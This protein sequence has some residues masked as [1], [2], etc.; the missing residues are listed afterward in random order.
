MIPLLIEFPVINPLAFHFGP[1]NVHWYGIMYLLGFL[2]TYLALLRSNV[3]ASKSAVADYIFMAALGVILGGRLG[4]ILFYNLSYYILHPLDIV[5]LW[6]GG[7]SFH[8]GLAGVVI[9]TTFFARIHKMSFWRITDYIVLVLPFT[10]ALGRI[11]NFINGE[12][13]GRISSL[14]WA[15]HFP[16]ASGYRHPSQLYEALLHISFGIILLTQK[17]LL[18]SPALLSSLFLIGYGVIRIFVEFFREPD[19]QIGFIFHY[20]TLG[21][22]LS[23]PILIVGLIILSSPPSGRK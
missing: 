21:Q 18:K 22:I 12:L 7:M 11:G 16:L 20:F 1:I 19:P 4:Y 10:L 8:G 2:L 13:Y 23:L 9:A 3:L 6:Q 15:I 5:A 17:R 14:P